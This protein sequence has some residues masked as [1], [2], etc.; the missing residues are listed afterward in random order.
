MNLLNF[1][2]TLSLGAFIGYL[3]ALLPGWKHQAKLWE[4]RAKRVYW[5]LREFSGGDVDSDNIDK[6]VASISEQIR[7]GYSNAS[8]L[9]AIAAAYRDVASGTSHGLCLS[10]FLEGFV[11]DGVVL[12]V[13]KKR[14]KGR[15]VSEGKGKSRAELRA[16]RFERV[17]K[18]A[19]EK[20]ASIP[21]ASITR[22]S[23][24]GRRE[25][26]AEARERK[27]NEI[28]RR[29]LAGLR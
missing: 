6:L 2:L 14:Q 21:S 13:E 9:R 4:G 24:A 26:T 18:K 27:A 16:L 15:F 11:G 3:I 5:L 17:L 28:A 10:R 19:R 23:K 8:R 25:T 22:R 20:V 12:V 1:L 7:N 29:E